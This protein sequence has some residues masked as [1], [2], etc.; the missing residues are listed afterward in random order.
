MVAGNVIS[1][2]LLFCC[3]FAV[4]HLHGVSLSCKTGI[5]PISAKPAPQPESSYVPSDV[6]PFC[7]GRST[8]TTSQVFFQERADSRESKK[9]QLKYKFHYT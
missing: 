4:F 1:V 2:I 5:Q 9:T 3:Y 6:T 7:F 8:I